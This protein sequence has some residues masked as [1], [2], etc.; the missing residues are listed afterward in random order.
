MPSSQ[1]GGLRVTSRE[2]DERNLVVGWEEGVQKEPLLFCSHLFSG[3]SR[4]PA[5]R[6][7]NRKPPSYA[8]I[9]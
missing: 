2:G 7:A 5:L 8:M 9:G 1:H 4:L 3:K 6:L